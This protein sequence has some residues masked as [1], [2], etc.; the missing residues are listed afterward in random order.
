MEKENI[1]NE[2]PIK[3]RISSYFFCLSP[4]L[5]HACI[6]SKTTQPLIRVMYY[7]ILSSESRIK[8]TRLWASSL[9]HHFAGISAKIVK[10]R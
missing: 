3:I 1:D 6:R 7:I 8:R 9:S 5:R 2:Q 4:A 10:Q